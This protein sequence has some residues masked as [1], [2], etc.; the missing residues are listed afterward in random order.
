MNEEN[1]DGD[2]LRA[3]SPLLLSLWSTDPPNLV[4]PCRGDS[5]NNA[6]T[7]QQ[8]EHQH[9]AAKDGD[10]DCFD[11]ILLHED[12][13]EVVRLAARLKTA[14]FE[15]GLAST[16]NSTS[17]GA[18]NDETAL[19]HSNASSCL[20]E[21]VERMRRALVAT[22]ENS[23]EPTI[24]IPR[25]QHPIIDSI[26]QDM[27]ERLQEEL[28]SL[29]EP[30]AVSPTTLSTKGGTPPSTTTVA[31]TPSTSSRKKRKQS[32][33]QIAIKYA[34]AQTDIL[35]QWMID[36]KDNPFPS[37]QDLATLAAATGL[38]KTQ[39]NNWATNVRK[40]NLKATCENGKKP[41]HFIDFLF[42]IR[43][44][45]GKQQQQSL[46]PQ[47]Q[48]QRIVSMPSFGS[49]SRNSMASIDHQELESSPRSYQQQQQPELRY[50]QKQQH[51]RPHPKVWNEFRSYD[52]SASSVGWTH[53]SHQRHT[54]TSS[55]E[56]Q[57]QH[58]SLGQQQ[59]RIHTSSTHTTPTWSQERHQEY[60]G[61]Q[62]IA[63]VFDEVDH[64]MFGDDG[65]G[66]APLAATEQHWSSSAVVEPPR[67]TSEAW[68]GVIDVDEQQSEADEIVQRLHAGSIESLDEE[69]LDK[70]VE[71]FDA[72]QQFGEDDKCWV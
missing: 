27:V 16:M 70:I 11:K 26:V 20:A 66:A 17:H 29:L 55:Y 41:H 46:P 15:L 47:Q 3:A 1:Y 38:T 40:R 60:D 28:N 48:Q 69:E 59:S 54:D 30:P 43:D 42:Y 64:A 13:A 34:K 8:Q 2:D 14:Q 19:G 71:E 12:F 35:M 6:V 62:S 7:S 5:N 24:E 10:E 63:T 39:V 31:T 23:S 61:M 56:Q 49:L 32:E 36:H 22:E 68:T 65:N 57:R 53:R 4:S 33:S 72:A 25:G 44:R 9:S 67:N 45:E 51:H 21:A 58:Y 18:A 52:E 50:Q 37:P